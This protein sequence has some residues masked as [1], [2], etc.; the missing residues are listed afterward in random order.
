MQTP[1]IVSGVRTPIGR[2]GGAFRDFSAAEL[3]AVVIQEALRRAGVRPQ[4]VDE[5][6]LGNVFQVNNDTYAARLAA[7]KAGIP[8]AVP[9]MAINRWCSSGL[10]AINIAAQLIMTGEIDIA[11][12]GGTENMS[13]TPFLLPYQVRFDAIRMGVPPA[14]CDALI[15]GLNCPVNA[16]HMGVTAENVAAK[17]GV[18]RQDQDE[19]ALLSQQRAGRAVQEGRFDQQIVPVAL[20]SRTVDRDEHPRPNTTI[21]ALAKLAPAFQEG[22]TVTAGNSSGINDGAAAVV[23]MSEEKASTLGLRPRL[24]WV[25][26][27]VA[28]VEPA[29]MGTGPVPAVRKLIDRTGVSLDDVDVIELNEAFAAQA[30]YCIKALGL[31]PERTNPNGSGI[32]LGHPTGATGAIMTVKA[33]EELDRVG[34]RYALIT[35][36]VGGGQGL[37]SLFERLN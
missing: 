24:R 10:E 28:G 29:L 2:Y 35:M 22:G 15:V 6:L 27:A 23:M 8:E 26:R 3:G 20:P 13:Q 17:H 36:C 5:V 34:G 16:Y 25:G 4:Q 21:E 14:I 30:A 7:L 37:A 31:D 9:A 33:M 12:A 32:S 1:V 11:V 18:T 19:L